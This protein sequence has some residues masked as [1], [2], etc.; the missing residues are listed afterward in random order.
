MTLRPRGW[1]RIAALLLAEAILVGVSGVPSAYAQFPDPQSEA[2]CPRCAVALAAAALPFEGTWSTPLTSAADPHWTREDFAAL[3]ARP[4]RFGCD[5]LG[6]VE[7][8]LSPLPLQI[9]REGGAFVLRYE[10]RG[11]VRTVPAVFEGDTLVVETH[12]ADVNA[13]ERYSVSADGRWL[14]LALTLAPAGK[15]ERPMTVTKRWL[16]TPDARIAS[17][18]CDVMSAGLEASLADFVDPHKLDTR[19]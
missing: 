17:H 8:A 5:K 14:N 18:G 1:M 15:G 4:L 12:D 19:R 13:T 7:Q 10:E 16:R 3:G 9:R 6:F 2:E 11:A